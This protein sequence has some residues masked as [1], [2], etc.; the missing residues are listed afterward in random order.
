MGYQRHLRSVRAG[1]SA[2]PATW[3]LCAATGRHAADRPLHVEHAGA[4]LRRPRTAAGV[5]PLVGP[6]RGPVLAAD[7]P[8][9]RA[10]HAHPATARPAGVAGRSWS[11]LTETHQAGASTRLGL[12]AARARRDH[13]AY[14]ATR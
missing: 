9:V 13:V 6:T 7:R 5:V 14:R 1:Q 2:P 10:G 12:R 3:P 4:G 8:A 11:G